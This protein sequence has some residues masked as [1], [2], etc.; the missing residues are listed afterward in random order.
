MTT[1]NRNTSVADYSSDRAQRRAARAEYRTKRRAA[2]YAGGGAFVAGV[3]LIAFGV[4]IMLH[5]MGLVQL[6]NGW[7]LFNLI[8]AAGSFATAYGAYRTNGGRLNS[9]VGGSILGGLVF[10]AIAAA[11]LFEW[12]LS[13]LLPAILI[14]AGVGMLFNTLLPD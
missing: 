7:A 11:F 6:H 14:V 13:L 2:R 5:N 10:T 12:N 3:A 4:I 1:D 8:P 9:M